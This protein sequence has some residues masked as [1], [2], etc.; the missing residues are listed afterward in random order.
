LSDYGC[1]LNRGRVLPVT[2]LEDNMG[3]IGED[4][5]KKISDAE[6]AGN[7]DRVMY[8]LERAM[9][10]A[11]ENYHTREKQEQVIKDGA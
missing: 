7:D 10:V 5:L 4:L 6:K 2:N 1:C 11:R 9:I 3:I 8:Y